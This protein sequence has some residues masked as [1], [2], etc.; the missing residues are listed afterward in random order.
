MCYQC[1]R[2]QRCSIWSYSRPYFPS[3]K[4]SE[5]LSI[6][7]M[8]LSPFEIQIIAHAS[9]ASSRFYFIFV[10]FDLFS[11][12]ALVSGIPILGPTFNAVGNSTPSALTALT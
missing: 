3:T 6:D 7:S 4:V 9:M 11:I 1:D 5:E 10:V 8:P 2:L 12:E